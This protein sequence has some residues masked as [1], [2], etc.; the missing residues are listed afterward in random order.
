M[1][2]DGHPTVQ[3]NKIAALGLAT[4]FAAIVCTADIG[5]RAAKPAAEGFRACLER[6]GV[7]PTDAAYVGDDIAKDF[8]APRALGMRTV[9]VVRQ[10]EAGFGW[11]SAGAATEADLVV[12]DLREAK[13]FLVRI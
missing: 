6:L 13:E 5:P 11:V 7:E 4:R 3:H 8:A 2:T 10:A 12:A 9:R 1:V